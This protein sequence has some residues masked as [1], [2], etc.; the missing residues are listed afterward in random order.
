MEKEDEPEI[1][2]Y[3]TVTGV[4]DCNHISCV[5]SDRVWVSDNK[6]NLIL[7]N[8]TGDTLHCLKDLCSI[9]FSGSHSVNNDNELIYIDRNYNIQKLSKNMNTSTTFIEGTDS[10]WRPRCVYL[11]PSSGDLL[12]GMHREDTKIGK[13]VRYNK[14]GNL[15]Q[16]IQRDNKGYAQY[17]K[18]HYITENNNGDIVVS[19]FSS[20]IEFGV[21]VVNDFGGRHRFAYT[22]NP[23]GSELKPWGICTDRLSNI[24]V[25][26]GITKAVHMMD[27]DGKFLSYFRENKEIRTPRSL[28][29]DFTTDRLLVGS[30]DHNK[31]YVYDRP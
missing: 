31:I 25:C 23:Q 19:D 14:N 7:I 13:V 28:G 29:Y 3:L 8:T 22:G 4:N 1:F 18:P 24:L 5:T 11:S 20:Y 6:A 9:C 12:V 10:T 30:M 26:D 17:S 15:T 27:K 2:Q 16:T 21:V